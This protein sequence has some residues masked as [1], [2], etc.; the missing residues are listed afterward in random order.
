M[1]LKKKENK[2][3]YQRLPLLT[4]LSLIYLMT[5]AIPEQVAINDDIV[6]RLR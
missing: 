5:E 4:L 2:P 3:N 1:V 6:L